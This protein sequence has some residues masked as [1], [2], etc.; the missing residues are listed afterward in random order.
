[1]ALIF[2]ITFRVLILNVLK[3][4]SHLIDVTRTVRDFCEFSTI[5]ETDRKY[6]LFTRFAFLLLVLDSI[7][8]PFLLV[9]THHM[10]LAIFSKRPIRNHTNNNNDDDL[11]LF[12]FSFLQLFFLH[13]QIS[14][15]NSISLF[16]GNSKF[17]WFFLIDDDG[18]FCKVF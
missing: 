7:V 16:R 14:E 13:Q 15:F 9:H 1:M 5:F 10:E 4:F 18:G 11:L 17:L 12:H 6:Y 2:F 8:V 3:L